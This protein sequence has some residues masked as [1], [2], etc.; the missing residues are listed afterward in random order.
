MLSKW[1]SV[2]DPSWVSILITKQASLRKGMWQCSC[3]PW[4]CIWGSYKALIVQYEPF[5]HQVNEIEVCEEAEVH[6]APGGRTEPGDKCHT[7]EWGWRECDRIWTHWSSDSCSGHRETAK[8]ETQ[9]QGRRI[10]SSIE[11]ALKRPRCS[12]NRWLGSSS[13][14]NAWGNPMAARASCV[15]EN[16]EGSLPTGVEGK[17]QSLRFAWAGASS[18]LNE[19]DNLGLASWL[20]K[21]KTE[22]HP[23]REHHWNSWKSLSSELGSGK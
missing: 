2:H 15:P 11:A 12:D 14:Y 21:Y 23:C 17:I 1:S 20:V 6:E 19:G 5:L 4:F 8:P 10:L 13:S 9:V 22:S 7:L 18:P 16:M 3:D